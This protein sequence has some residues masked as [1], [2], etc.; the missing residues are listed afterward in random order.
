MSRTPLVAAALV[1]MAALLVTSQPS[2]AAP[3]PAPVS[4]AIFTSD[5]SGEPVNL[6]HYASKEDVYLNGGPGINAPDDAAGLPDGTYY[7][8]VTDPSG[9]TL[10][11][12]D[13]IECRQFTVVG[14]VIQDATGTCPHVTG[15][16]G[17]DGGAT[18]Q[19]FP[20]N[21]TPNNGGVYKVW[22]TPIGSYDCDTAG[23]KHCFVPRQSKTDNFKVLEDATV[24]ID[25]RFWKNGVAQLGMAAY[26][27]DTNGA[28]NVKYSEYAPELLAFREAHI[29]A[30]EPGTHVVTVGDQDG[31]TISKVRG[32]RGENVRAGKDGLYR[33][34]V[35]VAVWRAGADV[36]Y[37]VEVTC[38]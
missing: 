12:T 16:D 1:S 8:Q 18:V 14:G 31:C 33:V 20:Y 26:W 23:N 2:S 32:A 36:T 22:V 37:R 5:S 21:N 24:E 25:A 27:T 28:S 11:S 38:R 19:L 35:D 6:N 9:R 17:E 29:E 15:E 10:L 34:A 30:V 3:D 13:L 7:F 4:G